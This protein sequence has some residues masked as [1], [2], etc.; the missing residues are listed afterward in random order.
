MRGCR[1]CPGRSRIGNLKAR[2]IRTCRVLAAH[3]KCEPSLV[4]RFTPAHYL[5]VFFKPTTRSHWDYL[6]PIALLGLSIF[7]VAF[8]YSA[9]F[10]VHQAPNTTWDA[11]LRQEWCKQIIYLGIGGAIYIAVS[12]R[13]SVA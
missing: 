10:S 13:K 2:P 8:I 4:I 6:S 3:V 1:T 9:Q 11:F 12:D 5:S 7:G